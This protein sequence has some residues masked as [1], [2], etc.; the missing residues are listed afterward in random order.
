MD[1]EPITVTL[2]NDAYQTEDDPQFWEWEGGID[3]D[4]PNALP[5]MRMLYDAGLRQRG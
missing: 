5:S 4:A 2:T 3:W 1:N